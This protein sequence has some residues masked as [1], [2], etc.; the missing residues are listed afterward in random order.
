MGVLL[1]KNG[2][3]PPLKQMAHLRMP[4]VVVLRIAAIQLPHAKREIRLRR[5][6]EEMIVIV[7]QA[8]GVADPAIAIHDMS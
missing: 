1:H 8:V 5:L 3:E 4:P 2:F 6:D 7:H